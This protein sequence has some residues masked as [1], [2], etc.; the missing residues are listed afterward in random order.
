MNSNTYNIHRFKIAQRGNY[1]QYPSISVAIGELTR[2]RKRS[3]WIWYVF[4]QIAGLGDSKMSKYYD[5]HNLCEACHFLND[6][7]LF[8]NYFKIV[9]ILLKHLKNHNSIDST[10]QQNTHK[11]HKSEIILDRIFGSLDAEKVISSLTLFYIAGICFS[12]IL[13][14]K[15]SQNILKKWIKI[16]VKMI[17]DCFIC[18]TDKTVPDMLT[19]KKLNMNKD[20]IDFL[21]SNNGIVGLR[22]FF[23][24]CHNNY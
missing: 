11:K 9:A 8:S 3:H 20:L 7:E 18:I 21:D 24:Y 12:K 2:G 17:E 19:L 4:P 1:L 6:K 23:Q 5:I 16:L 13:E 22:A 10:K 15:G 14:T